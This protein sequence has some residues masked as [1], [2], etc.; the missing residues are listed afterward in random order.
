LQVRIWTRKQVDVPRLLI[1]RLQM[2]SINWPFWRTHCAYASITVLLNLV[3]YKVA[4]A[5]VPLLACH[6]PFDC[7]MLGLVIGM[8]ILQ[9]VPFVIYHRTLSA[10]GIVKSL[11]FLGITVA[12]FAFWDCTIYIPV[13]P[14]MMLRTLQEHDLVS[15]GVIVTLGDYLSSPL[16]VAEAVVLGLVAAVFLVRRQGG[17]AKAKG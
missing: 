12:L 11:S 9:T 3:L 10:F 2:P 16:R 6:F 15:R 1:G 8:S 14:W 13:I 17:I 5:T 7:C 4:F